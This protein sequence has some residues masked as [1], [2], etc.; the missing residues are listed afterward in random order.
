MANLRTHQFYVGTPAAGGWTDAYTVP[1]GYVINV[2]TIHAFNPSTSLTALA[3]ARIDPSL[4]FWSA[5]CAITGIQVLNSTYFVLGPGQ[6]LA[7]F[8][9]TG[10]AV[11]YIVS[12]YLLT[13]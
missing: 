4:Q 11:A 13:I 9:S 10:R 5:T 2:K 3:S 8:N 6:T 12:G 7:L 1:A